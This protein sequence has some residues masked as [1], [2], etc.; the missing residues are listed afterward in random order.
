[1]LRSEQKCVGIAYASVKEVL[2]L[3]QVMV[4]SQFLIC[5]QEYCT[6]FVMFEQRIDNASEW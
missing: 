3:L 4:Q 1:M 5:N 6:R 2:H